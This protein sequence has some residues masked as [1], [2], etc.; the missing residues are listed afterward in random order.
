MRRGRRN[1]NATRE[2]SNEPEALDNENLPRTASQGGPISEQDVLPDT[3]DQDEKNDANGRL[4][5]TSNKAQGQYE[6]LRQRNDQLRVT[7]KGS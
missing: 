2:I 7:Q 1:V 5:L 4:E 6:E 3:F